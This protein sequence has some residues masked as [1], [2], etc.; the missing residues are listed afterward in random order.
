MEWFVG[1]FQI[2]PPD[3]NHNKSLVGK[4]KVGKDG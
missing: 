3:I 4:G 2:L 1:V